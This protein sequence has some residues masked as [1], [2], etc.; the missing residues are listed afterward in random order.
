MQL[1]R[2]RLALL[3]SAYWATM[4]WSLPKEGNKCVRA[5]LHLK[6]E[7]QVGNEWSNILPKSLQV[8]KEP[9]PH[10]Q[11]L[12]KSIKQLW[13]THFIT[14]DFSTMILCTVGNGLRYA[15]H[16]S[17]HVTPRPLYSF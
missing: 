13:E 12:I 7:V 1:I 11:S 8:R 9:P 6:Q 15:A 4:D 17:F 16:A 5:D 3:I 14:K 2:E 10:T